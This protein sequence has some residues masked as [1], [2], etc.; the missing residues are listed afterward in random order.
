MA[1]KASFS[2]RTELFVGRLVVAALVSLD[3]Q[4]AITLALG[5]RPID[6]RPNHA[7]VPGTAYLAWHT[8]R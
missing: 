3:S 1:A 2:V 4:L 6:L 5:R 8:R 7:S